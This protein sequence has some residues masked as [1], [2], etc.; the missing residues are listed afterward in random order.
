MR[1]A[2]SCPSPGANAPFVDP[3]YD[4]A[5]DTLG[6]GLIY[7]MLE[8]ASDLGLITGSAGWSICPHFAD[9]ET[10]NGSMMYSADHCSTWLFCSGQG[11]YH[12]LTIA[13][14]T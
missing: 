10:D 8:E 7:A 11:R 14:K 3:G 4:P 13:T 9:D 1:E 6:E 2:R 5:T 12:F